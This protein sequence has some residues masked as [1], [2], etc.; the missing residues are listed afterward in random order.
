MI[1]GI[2]ESKRL[3]KRISCKFKCKFFGRN[4]DSNQK[5]NNNKC[6]CECKIKKKRLN[7]ESCYMYL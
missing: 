5:W 6:Q 2:N 1:I 7:W 4:H 3:T